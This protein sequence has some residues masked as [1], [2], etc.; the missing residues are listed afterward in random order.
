ME[1]KEKQRKETQILCIGE[2][3]II[4]ATDKEFVFRHLNE[5]EISQFKF[6]LESYFVKDAIKINP[7]ENEIIDSKKKGVGTYLKLDKDK[8]RYSCLEYKGDNELNSIIDNVF[9]LTSIEPRIIGRL[10][11]LNNDMGGLC[12]NEV[13]TSIYYSEMKF[14]D[15]SIVKEIND[16]FIKE[17]KLILNA[18][19]EL[20][21]EYS[22]VIKSIQDFKEICLMPNTSHFKI[23]GYFSVVENLLTSGTDKSIRS[24]L[25]NK[26]NLLNNRFEVPLEWNSYFKGSNT[27][28]LKTIIENAYKYR[29]DIAHGNEIDFDKK[30]RSLNNNIQ[31]RLFLHDLTK[32][33]L[34]YS[35][36]EPQLIKDLKNC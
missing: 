16:E 28:S 18:Y 22:F 17:F 30:L 14:F 33:L 8:F 31:V 32:K 19:I 3:L 35:L 21:D 12:F 20:S 15:N 7:Y 9:Y 25:G 36:N 4:K 29:N 23:I 26:I 5:K 24:E 2:P 27:T 11:Y 1:L 6:A 10:V 13:N 34:V